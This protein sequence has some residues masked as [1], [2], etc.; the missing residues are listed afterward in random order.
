MQKNSFQNLEQDIY[1][2]TLKNGFQVY[3]IPYKYKKNYYAILGTKY[4]SK[5]DDVWTGV[6]DT[7]DNFF[8]REAYDVSK[9][10][11]QGR[12]KIKTLFDED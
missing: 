4:G 12:A 5:N 2:F 11:A 10:E 6:R 1:S 7:M 3:L 8:T 9:W